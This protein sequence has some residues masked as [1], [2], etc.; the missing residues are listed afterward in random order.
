MNV[1]NQQA[2]GGARYYGIWAD[3]DITVYVTVIKIALKLM[4]AFFLIRLDQSRLTNL[5]RSRSI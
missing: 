1:A 4:T 2:L 5:S 3:N